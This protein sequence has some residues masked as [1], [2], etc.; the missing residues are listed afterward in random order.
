MPIDLPSIL[1]M[2][3]PDYVQALHVQLSWWQLRW[4]QPWPRARISLDERHDNS[5]VNAIRR[6]R[7]D[8]QDLLTNLSAGQR[9][10]L[11]GD[12]DEVSNT[13]FFGNLHAAGTVTQLLRSPGIAPGT[14]ATIEAARLSAQR[15]GFRHVTARDAAAPWASIA[16]VHDFGPASASRLLLAERPDLYFMLNEASRSGMELITAHAL[17]QQ[18]VMPS[19]EGHYRAMLEAIY[20]APW[21]RV[22]PP[23]GSRDF[24]IWGQRVAL[25]DVFA[26]DEDG[27]RFP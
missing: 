5:W 17:P 1:Q 15:L 25:L 21:C 11:V 22:P 8:T 26:Y 2:S 23:A 14:V 3:W 12:Q 9:E 20:A 6:F 4:H 10:I 24:F 19:L 27:T 18:L 16:A 7:S 13:Y